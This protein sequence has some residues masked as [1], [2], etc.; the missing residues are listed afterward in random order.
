[1]IHQF[2]FWR[3]NFYRDRC[4]LQVGSMFIYNGDYCEV[5]TMRLNNFVYS[6]QINGW[7]FVMS[8]K[9]YLNTPSAKGRRL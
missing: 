1:M 2:N 4:R 3:K 5:L 6:K 7:T 8:Y 9:D